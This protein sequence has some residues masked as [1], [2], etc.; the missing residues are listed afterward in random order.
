MILA[1]FLPVVLAC[2][3]WFGLDIGKRP[4]LAGF[5]I[6][7]GS[8]LIGVAVTTFFLDQKMKEEPGKWTWKSIW[9]ELTFSNIFHLKNRV[10]PTIQYIPDLWAYLI[11]GLIPHLV[12]VVFVNA[13][14]TKL[15]NGDSKFFH[16][17]GYESTPFQLMGVI[18][19]IF[20][21]IT[22]LAGFFF[23]DIYAPLAT[24]WEEENK[25][26]EGGKASEGE[27]SDKPSSDSP[28]EEE[29]ALPVAEVED[30]QE[31]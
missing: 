21:L 30:E 26:A 9:W 2:S 22:F 4:A 12:I 23:P 14:A 29:Q 1:N 16:Y 15:D 17:G 25:E 11:K 20:T 28:Y 5:M 3:L 31:A 6:L 13:A 10:T 27:G 8:S 19:F 18:C 24:A 7:I